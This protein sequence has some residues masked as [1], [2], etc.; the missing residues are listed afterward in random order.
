MLRLQHLKKI[1]NGW[2]GLSC[3]FHGLSPVGIILTKALR[4][5][6]LTLIICMPVISDPIEPASATTTAHTHPIIC[7]IYCPTRRHNLLTHTPLALLCTA[8]GLVIN[9]ST[10]RY[11]QLA[12]CKWEEPPSRGRE[13]ARVHPGQWYTR[14]VSL[15]K[16]LERAENRKEYGQQTSKHRIRGVSRR[17]TSRPIFPPRHSRRYRRHEHKHR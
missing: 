7:I 3:F 8:L 12:S 2:I 16:A 14:L 13:Y 11:P 4:K 9:L 17:Q 15:V 10:T 1:S 5:Q 6:A